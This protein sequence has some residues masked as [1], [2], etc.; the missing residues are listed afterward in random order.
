M[1]GL[2]GTDSGPVPAASVPFTLKLYF[3]PGVRP[4]MVVRGCHAGLKASLQELAARSLVPVQLAV[5]AQRWPPALEAAIYF[6]CSEALANIA[7]YAQASQVQLHVTSNGTRLRAEITDDGVGGADPATGSGLRGLADRIEALGGHL[8]I[9]SPPGHGTR[10]TADLP[11]PGPLPQ[12]DRSMA[13]DEC[14]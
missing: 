13:Q 11:L 7:K 3:C 8:T 12:E 4:E 6:I 9:T 14:G 2:E 10:L 1:T 5:P